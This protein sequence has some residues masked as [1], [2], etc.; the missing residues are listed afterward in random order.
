M[1]RP[2]PAILT[3]NFSFVEDAVTIKACKLKYPKFYFCGS[4]TLKDNKLEKQTVDNLQWKFTRGFI[5]EIDG[6]GLV[7][8][9]KWCIICENEHYGNNVLRNYEGYCHKRGFGNCVIIRPNKEE[10]NLN[11]TDD[12]LSVAREYKALMIVIPTGMVGSRLK[13]TLTKAIQAKYN[14]YLQFIKETNANNRNAVWGSLEDLMAKIGN[15]MCIDLNHYYQI[16]MK[17]LIIVNVGH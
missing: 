9:E 16:E 4:N 8:L 7:R 13:A 5:N 10:C 14:C 12:V 11:D 3:S 2:D 15:V 6:R 1:K 17:Q